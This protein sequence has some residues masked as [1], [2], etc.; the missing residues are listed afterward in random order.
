MTV[1]LPANLGTGIDLAKVQQLVLS[2]GNCP[3]QRIKDALR[4]AGLL[5]APYAGTPVLAATNLMGGRPGMNFVVAHHDQFEQL[6]VDSLTLQPFTGTSKS[7]PAGTEVTCTLPADSVTLV[8]F[9][10][11]PDPVH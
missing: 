7:D 11:F 5:Q 9:G 1:R 4:Q 3:M 6:V 8:A 2:E 10:Q